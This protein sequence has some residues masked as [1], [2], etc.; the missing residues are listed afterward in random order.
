[1]RG[2]D[3]YSCVEKVVD[4]LRDD[5]VDIYLNFVVSPWNTRE[6]LK[7]VIEFC[8]KHGAYL[9]A[10]FY[11]NIE[12]FDTTRRAGHLYRID[13]L[14]TSP[15]LHSKP[16]P[17]F[18]LYTHWASGNLKIPCFNVLLRPVIRPNGDVELCEGKI[19]KLGNLYEKSLGE[20]WHSKRTAQLQRR[21]IRC[22]AC[23]SDGQRA[24]DI[25]VASIFKTFIPS[26]LLNVTF[27]KCDW[28][29]IPLLG[30]R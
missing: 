15:P 30:T 9:Q 29:K 7:H 12:Y 18:G 16:H 24:M 2:V 1:M 21:Y 26:R 4:E 20:I 5:D 28:D 10:G 11:E 14:L 6:D 17:Y 3:G 19:V 25:R 27:G 23:W 8:K 22:N 13:D